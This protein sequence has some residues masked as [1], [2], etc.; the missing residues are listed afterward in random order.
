MKTNLLSLAPY[1]KPYKKELYYAF[2]ALAINAVLILLFGKGIKYLVDLGLNVSN[3]HLNVI[4]LFFIIAIVS[5]AV[6]GYYRSL[7]INS[8]AEKIINDIKQKIYSHIINFPPNFF[9]TAKTG[10]I[11]SRLTVDTTVIH[12][13]ISNTISF[14][15]RNT[16]L[17]CGGLI[18]L[19]L[20]NVKLSLVAIVIIL[21]A[22]LPIIFMGK[23]LKKISR[24]TQNATAVVS[25]HIEETLNGIQTIQ[26]YLC[27]QKEI[28]NFN[29]HSNKALKISLEKTNFKAMLVALV[30]AIS[31]GAV[32][33]VVLV[34]G[35][36]VLA[37]K[38]TSGE[39]SSFLFYAVLVATA[40]VA[41]SQNATQLQSA[42]GSLARLLELFQI[43][44]NN[45]I[46]GNAKPTISL[47]INITFCKVDFCYQERT[48]HQILNNFNLQI[49]YGE[50]IGIVGM[51]GSGKSTILQLLLGFYQPNAGDILLNEHNISG[52]DLA[53]LRQQFA[54]I[55][56]NCFIFSGTVFDNI[57][58]V[59]KN[60]SKQ[61]V[62]DIINNN[63][64]LHFISELPNG[65][66]TFVGEK[67]V[68][69]SGGER[70]RIAIARAIIK[71]SP[72]L[73]LDEATS[74]LDNHNQQLI[75]QTINQFNKTV[76]II[77]HRLSFLNNCSRIVFVNNG[78]IVESGN[79]QQL[80]ALNG[81]YR[82]MYDSENINS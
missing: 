29:D 75:L 59:N 39:L 56:Q 45:K 3:P 54:Y 20:T 19:F 72:I 30:I 13:V 24:Q 62:L 67:G 44:S 74:A 63:P 64:A 37:G 12:N 50:K 52:L 5:L 60:I 28:N 58:Y 42:N 49:N 11:I 38:I 46:D 76:I 27:E 18:L 48:E 70:Q 26:A 53:V 31:F 32:A 57:A 35:H 21:I 16:A 2:F 41:I 47:P 1:F 34:G 77:A 17:F 33:M 43:N 22:T 68:Q 80:L 10:D 14:L 73:L 9:T 4:M 82:K 78:N 7:L 79:H 15:L 36:D 25:S 23:M 40:L 65:I 81:F 66:D 8:V 71:D 61:Q 69:L 51:S 6:S 55:S